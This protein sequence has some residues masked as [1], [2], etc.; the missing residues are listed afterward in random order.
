MKKEVFKLF[1]EDIPK[2]E[3][4][5]ISFPDW[6]SVTRLE[7]LGLNEIPVTFE[8]KGGMIHTVTCGKCIIEEE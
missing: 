3:I 7:C 8:C 2:G 1:K 4:I 6:D 5:S